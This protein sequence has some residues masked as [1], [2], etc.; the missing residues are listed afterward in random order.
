[1]VDVDLIESAGA[2]VKRAFAVIAAS[3]VLQ[4]QI[5]RLAESILEGSDS[6]SPIDIAEKIVNYRRESHALATMQYIGERYNEE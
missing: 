3:G 4:K 2:E 6:E 5:A 1:M